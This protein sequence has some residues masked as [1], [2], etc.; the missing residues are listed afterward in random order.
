[1]W[2]YI[3]I[4]I[5]RYMGM[6]VCRGK[7][8]YLIQDNALIN[9]D[10]LLIYGTNLSAIKPFLR[11]DLKRSTVLDCNDGC[12]VVKYIWLLASERL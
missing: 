3:Y 5:Y 11:S 2:A 6:G 7:G 4:R 12:C 9:S 8:E 10:A 1:M